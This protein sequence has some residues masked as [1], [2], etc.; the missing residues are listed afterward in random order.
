MKLRRVINGQ[1]HVTDWGKWRTGDKTPRTAYPL[2]K[3]SFKPS[4]TYNCRLVLFECLGE[5]FRLLMGYRLDLARGFFMLAR[6]V[7]GDMLTLARYEYHPDEPGW[8]LHCFCDDTGKVSGR[9]KCDDKRIPTWD[10]FHKQY[11]FDISGETEMFDK[12]VT[13]F[14][15]RKIPPLEL[16]G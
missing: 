9:T 14:R 3:H 12:A 5:K 16:V 8:H 4:G 13:V 2:S 10:G 15:L 7:G 11:E 1:K 6:D